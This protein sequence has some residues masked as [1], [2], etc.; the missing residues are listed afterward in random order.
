MTKPKNTS[1]HG[2]VRT[3]EQAH[4]DADA[5]R[6]RSAGHTYPQIAEIQGTTKATAYNR[7]QRALAS[8]PSEAV[9]EYRAIQREQL[10]K[11]MATYLPEALAGNVKAAE[12]V[13]KLI[14]R[15]SKLEGTD[16]PTKHE[17]ITL[18]AIQAEIIRLEAALDHSATETR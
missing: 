16:S 8:I 6:L 4:L 5:L 14:E 1:P 10:D 18:D 17:V 11:L 3:E 9:E 12:F 2:F 15:R 13:L 7:V